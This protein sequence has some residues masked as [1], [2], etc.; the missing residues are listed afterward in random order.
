[1]KQST[2]KHT[3]KEQF[4]G[5]NILELLSENDEKSVLQ[6]LRNI[7]KEHNVTESLIDYAKNSSTPYY[8]VNLKHNLV[9]KIG[10]ISSF[11]EEEISLIIF[12]QS[13][14]YTDLYTMGETFPRSDVP[15]EETLI[16][17][18]LE[19]YKDSV[20]VSIQYKKDNK[21]RMIGGC[22]IAFNKSDAN[23]IEAIDVKSEV[24]SKIPTFQSLQVTKTEDTVSHIFKNMK[25]RDIVNPIR[26]WRQDKETLLELGIT[27]YSLASKIIAS[28]PFGYIRFSEENNIPVPP[29]ALVDTHD[30]HVVSLIEDQFGAKIFAKNGELVSTEKV[31][32]SILMYH[33]GDE[34]F[35]GYFGSKLVFSGGR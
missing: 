28:I 34:S 24:E 16:A 7:Q 9:L 26:F 19:G 23:F 25:E 17:T 32:S 35:G 4:A 30:H 27:D 18:F 11:S 3:E 29:F 10:A 22:M 5:I 1:M 20:V 31:L 8:E 21:R 33:Y 15:H 12:E 14:I 2:A 6:A 13:R